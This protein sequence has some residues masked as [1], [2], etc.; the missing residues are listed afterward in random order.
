MLWQWPEHKIAIVQLSWALIEVEIAGS[1]SKLTKPAY[2][3]LRVW[4]FLL[5]EKK[6]ESID[7]WKRHKREW[8]VC[9]NFIKQK[10]SYFQAVSW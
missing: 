3:K 5:P 4:N 8:F 9:Y 6:N 1:K 2:N 10:E 7:T